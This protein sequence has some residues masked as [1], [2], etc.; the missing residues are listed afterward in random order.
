[1]T[2]PVEEVNWKNKTFFEIDK[3]LLFTPEE[4]NRAIGRMIRFHKYAGGVGD[5]S[6]KKRK[7]R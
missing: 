4:Y 2:C 6:T 7:K 1:M 3:E 5:S